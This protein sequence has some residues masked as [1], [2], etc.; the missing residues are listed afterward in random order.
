[1]GFVLRRGHVANA[2]EDTSGIAA[3]VI[4][5]PLYQAGLY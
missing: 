2:S 1:M 3:L 4:E 5:K